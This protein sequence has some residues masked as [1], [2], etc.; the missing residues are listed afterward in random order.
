[1][2]SEPLATQTFTGKELDLFEKGAPDGEDGEGWYYF[3]ARY[4]SADVG[5][6]TTFL[7]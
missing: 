4:Y 6:W 5:V 1:P 7:Q 3:G 2:S